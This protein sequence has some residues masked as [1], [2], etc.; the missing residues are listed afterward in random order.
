VWTSDQG[1][2]D[3]EKYVTYDSELVLRIA[4]YFGEI[5]E[6]A[7]SYVGKVI[8]RLR[9]LSTMNRGGCR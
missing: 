6:A 9:R 2:A 3:Q 7:G 5:G 1:L 4:K 8:H